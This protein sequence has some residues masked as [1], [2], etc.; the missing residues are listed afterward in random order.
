MRAR[1]RLGIRLIPRHLEGASV[2][3]PDYSADQSW[4]SPL[5]LAPASS[6][7]E[8][9]GVDAGS[10]RSRAR[11]GVRCC[12]GLPAR[13]FRFWKICPRRRPVVTGVILEG[14]INSDRTDN[15][16]ALTDWSADTRAGV[17]AAALGYQPAAPGVWCGGDCANSLR[18]FEFMLWG[19]DDHIGGQYAAAWLIR[20][21]VGRRRYGTCPS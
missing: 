17:R 12:A 8:S 13:C 2:T 15:A 7:Q 5:G 9:G 1:R 4:L 3:Y 18:E 19:G 16:A 14:S 10:C 21:R 11:A 6:P 20:I